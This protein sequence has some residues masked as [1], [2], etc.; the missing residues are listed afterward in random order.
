MKDT[1][2][3]IGMG[4]TGAAGTEIVGTMPDLTQM[5]TISQIIIQIVIGIVTLFHLHKANKPKPPAIT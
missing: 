5:Q 2:T 1:L 4:I 3:T